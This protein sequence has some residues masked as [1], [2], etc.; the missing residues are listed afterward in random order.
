MPAEF[1][2]PETPF[3]RPM[4]SE[5]GVSRRRL[6]DAIEAG[7][8]R[9]VL[10]GVF[11]RADVADTIETRCQAARLVVSSH[12]VVCDRTAAWLHGVDVLDFHETEILP[13]VETY[14]LRWHAPAR[15]SGCDGGTRDLAPCDVMTL[16]GLR[17]TTPLRTAL[18]LGCKLSPRRGLAAIDALMRAC[19][20]T[21]ADLDREL[22]RYRR[23]RGVVRLRRLV[24]LADPR[25]ESSGESWVRWDI[26]A[27]GFPPPEPQCW[28]DVAGVPTYRLDLAYPRHRVAIEYDGEEFHTADDHRERDKKRRKWLHDHGWIVIVVDRSSFTNRAVDAWL[29]EIRAALASRSKNVLV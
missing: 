28:V 2:F 1:V 17:V 10:R 7:V 4:L 16:G 22:P 15:R 13:P 29:Q 21:R 25:S 23:R 11:V 19:G 14:V 8:V 24:S 27:A 20:V 5:Y 6:E 26:S 12:S 9:R 18:D 3:T